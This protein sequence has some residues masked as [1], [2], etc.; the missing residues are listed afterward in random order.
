MKT[1]HFLWRIARYLFAT[2][3]SIVVTL[4]IPLVIAS[5][6]FLIAII[7]VLMWIFVF[8]IVLL[9]PDTNV[10]MDSPMGVV[11]IPFLLSII[12]IVS[13]S[14]AVLIA[15]IFNLVVILPFSIFVEIL[16]KQLGLRN[17]ILRLGTFLGGGI[18]LGIIVGII[19]IFLANKFDAKISLLQLIGTGAFLG[20]TCVIAEFVFGLALMIAD[21]SKIILGVIGRKIADVRERRKLPTSA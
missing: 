20:A 17:W 13:V 14:T 8:I 7:W 4:V 3:V 5:I 16:N 19:G 6:P 1:I 21:I 10:P 11:L 18:L 12:G 15:V 2:S 9:I